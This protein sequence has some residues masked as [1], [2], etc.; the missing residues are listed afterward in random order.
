MPPGPYERA[1]LIASYLKKN[2]NRTK[3]I[4]LD[5]NQKIVSKGKLFME[6]WKNNYTDIIEYR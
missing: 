3:L 5:A 4:I 2:K 1:S 6:Y